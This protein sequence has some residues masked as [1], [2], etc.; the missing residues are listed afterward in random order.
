MS[1]YDRVRSPLASDDRRMG[2]RQSYLSDQFTAQPVQRPSWVQEQQRRSDRYL[3]LRELHPEFLRSLSHTCQ[4]CGKHGLGQRKKG[5]YGHYAFHHTDSDAYEREIVGG[6]YVLVCRRCH[7]FVHF[8]GG[9]L[10]LKKGAVTRQDQK[11]AKRAAKARRPFVKGVSPGSFPNTMQKAFNMV[12]W[13]P[14]SYWDI[15]A[16]IFF[17]AVAALIASVILAI[18]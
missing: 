11:A 16:A 4:F 14:G 2:V 15:A 6:N 8:L 10:A 1:L 5:H 13:F 3:E 12:C 7:W 17:A 18:L 9:E